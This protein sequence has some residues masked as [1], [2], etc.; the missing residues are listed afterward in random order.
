M[1]D[2]SIP[3]ENIRATLTL[4]GGNSDIGVDLTGTDI[5]VGAT[6]GGTVGAN[7]G[8]TVGA[9]LS[10]GVA[11]DVGL[12]DVRIKEL[13][14]IETDSSISVK[15]LPK[16]ET[17]STISVKE[18]PKIEVDLGLDNI[19]IAEFPPLQLELGFRPFRLHLPVNFKFCL[20]VLGVTLFKFSVC[21]EGMAIGEDNQPRQAEQCK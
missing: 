17:D 5:A 15:E 3:W 4:A 7:L 2:I 21:G 13:P 6:L 18:L 12:D 14:K 19:R 10:G 1:S 8:G 20:E 16:I 11:V 9:N